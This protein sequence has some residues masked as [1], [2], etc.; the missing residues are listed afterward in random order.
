MLFLD[1]IFR[2][3]IVILAHLVEMPVSLI[4]FRVLYKKPAYLLHVVG[5]LYIL[6]ASKLNI[7]LLIPFS[8]AVGTLLQFFIRN[9]A[10]RILP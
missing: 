10:L 6:S 7:L 9:I 3:L 1:L 4:L 2:N 8:G 5:F